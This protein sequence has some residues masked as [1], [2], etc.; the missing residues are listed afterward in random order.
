MNND[1]TTERLDFKYCRNNIAYRLWEY[2]LFAVCFGVPIGGCIFAQKIG[3]W[4]FND[5]WSVVLAIGVAMI[6]F[7]CSAALAGY[8]AGIITEKEGL[9]LFGKSELEIVLA[10]RTERIRY[11]EIAAVEYDKKVSNIDSLSFLPTAKLTI[12]LKDNRV[13]VIHSSRAE[14]RKKR[15][16][17]GLVWWRKYKLNKDGS[18]P[19]PDMSLWQV[20]TLLGRRSTGRIAINEI[21]ENNIGY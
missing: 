8:W 14:A 16:E 10:K 6:W 19:V 15:R 12:R 13:I 3:G 11:D 20:C 4:A 18:I 5:H 7:V 1:H 21:I 17:H 9:A 2:G